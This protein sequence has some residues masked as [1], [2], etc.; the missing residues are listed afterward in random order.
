MAAGGWAE[1]LGSSQEYDLIFRMLKNGARP[2]FHEEVR[3]LPTKSSGIPLF[4]TKSIC[5]AIFSGSSTSSASRNCR[6]AP[7]EACIPA[8][9]AAQAAPIGLVQYLQSLSFAT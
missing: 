8:L 6:Y 3:E 9:R 5:R 1:G 4:L 7:A 2:A